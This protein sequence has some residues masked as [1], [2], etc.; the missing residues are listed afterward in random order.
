MVAPLIVLI[1][2]LF[3]RY[4]RCH[5]EINWL[6]VVASCNNWR[7]IILILMLIHY[8]YAFECFECF[9]CI[10]MHS[11]A[12]ICIQMVDDCS[13]LV[14]LMCSTDIPCKASKHCNNCAKTN[15]QSQIPNLNNKTNNNGGCKYQ[16]YHVENNYD[17][18]WCKP[19]I[20]LQLKRALNS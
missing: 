19:S 17:H 13:P 7:I 12:F 16:S 6:S 4:L 15:K 11:N 5:I 1:A 9:K 18:W 3:E 10:Q 20:H 8:L 14:L 2:C